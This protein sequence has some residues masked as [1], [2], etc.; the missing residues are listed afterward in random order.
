MSVD[1]ICYLIICAIVLSFCL[2]YFYF[3]DKQD[4]K[5]K[6]KNDLYFQELINKLDNI[7]RSIHEKENKK[8]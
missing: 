7:E 5:R 2:V 8:E 3:V 6:N 1:L 4:K